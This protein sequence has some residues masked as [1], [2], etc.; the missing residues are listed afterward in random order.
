MTTASETATEPECVTKVTSYGSQ[1]STPASMTKIPT[2]PHEDSD[3]VPKQS[4]TNLD[5]V[6]STLAVIEEHLN[7]SADVAM[8]PSPPIN[9]PVGTSP[10]PSIVGRNKARSNVFGEFGDRI[11]E[12]LFDSRNRRVED[13]SVSN[14]SVRSFDPASDE[15][16]N[17][18]ECGASDDM[19]NNSEMETGIS[20]LFLYFLSFFPIISNMDLVPICLGSPRPNPLIEEYE[21]YPAEGGVKITHD[22]ESAV[23][24]A[25]EVSADS[26]TESDDASKVAA[27]ELPSTT[28]ADRTASF[29]SERGVTENSNWADE[30]ED[31]LAR[32]IRRLEQLVK[33]EAS[34]DSSMTQEQRYITRLM[35]L[36]E[37]DERLYPIEITARPKAGLAS[38]SETD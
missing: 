27:R 19:D 21:A 37:D 8:L 36:L 14:Q 2:T 35:R 17:G 7:E 22:N 12:V 16:V 11:A 24:S 9:T 15:S 6:S 26:A 33:D 23:D 20:K 13:D 25:V 5:A 32:A 30:C 38:N 31:G 4:L 3:Q 29:K 34:T 28:L 10:E 18:S 1:Y